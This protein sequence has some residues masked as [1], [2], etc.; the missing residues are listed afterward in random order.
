MFVD[1]AFAVIEESAGT[2]HRVVA[3]GEV[4]VAFAAGFLGV[5]NQDGGVVSG[6]AFGDAELA[7][8][9]CGFGEAFADERL[10]FER[11][12]VDELG[13]GS[14]FGDGDRDELV[15]AGGASAAAGSG[16]SGGGALLEGDLNCGI[17]D[18]AGGGEEVFER[19]G[20]AGTSTLT[21]CVSPS[22]RRCSVAHGVSPMAAPGMNRELDYTFW[23]VVAKRGC[24]GAVCT[25]TRCVSTPLNDLGGNLSVDSLYRTVYNDDAC[26]GV[27]MGRR[28]LA[29]VLGVLCLAVR[30]PRRRF[31]S[32]R[33]SA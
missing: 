27:N 23:K 7:G 4:E 20:V 16:G 15:A 13:E 18:G 17:G 6:G 22:T 5:E 14:R 26:V 31:V 2:G 10:A 30:V 28:F 33:P 11:H 29:V 21:L 12:G 1:A 8:A 9:A 19:A 32:R 3:A 25:R 24:F